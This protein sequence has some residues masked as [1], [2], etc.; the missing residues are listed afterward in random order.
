MRKIK[1]REKLTKEGLIISILKSESSPL[2]NNFMKH[3]SN[4]NTDGD[5]YDDKKTV[6]ISDVRIILSRWGHILTKNDRKKIT[7]ELYEIEKKGKP[8]K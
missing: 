5:T 8:F 3:F 6:K 1:N 4:N 7:K 2:E